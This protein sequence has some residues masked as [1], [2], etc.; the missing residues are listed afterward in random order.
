MYNISFPPH[1]SQQRRQD[2]ED[3]LLFLPLP[4]LVK[5]TK[6][7]RFSEL[8]PANRPRISP[9]NNN[10]SVCVFP[11]PR[12]PASKEHRIISFLLIFFPSELVSKLGKAM[13]LFIFFA[14][15]LP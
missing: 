7:L 8:L 1:L 9:S 15:N 6:Q 4:P 10:Y 14:P 5:K 2:C 13:A 12:T 3:F 11:F